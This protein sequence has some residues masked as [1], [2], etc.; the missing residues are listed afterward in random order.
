VQIKNLS[1]VNINSDFG[2]GTNYFLIFKYVKDKKG[3]KLD[4]NLVYYV[5]YSKIKSLG[6]SNQLSY[7]PITIGL[8]A[9]RS[10]QAFKLTNDS[11]HYEIFIA[12]SDWLCENMDSSG[13]WPTMHNKKIGN[14]TLFAPWPSAMSQGLGI[15]VLT[16]AYKTT[17]D[18]T[19]IVSARK[20]ILS[21]GKTIEEGGVRTNNKFGV[22]YEEYPL[23]SNSTH[24]LNGFIY[25]LYGLYDLWHLD[26]NLLAKEYFEDGVST[27]K[28]VLPMYDLG[29]W[30]SYD[31]NPNKNLRNHWGYCSPWYQKLHIAQLSSIYLITEEKIFDD[32]AKKFTQQEHSSFIN[33]IIYPAYI[34][35]TDFVYLKRSI[36]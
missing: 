6:V 12:N 25:S 9:L 5:D 11:L 35:Y 31:L 7:Y 29:N 33:Y 2:D 4:S 8:G 1:N 10:L 3:I 34:L 17:Y 13:N 36:L 15:S 16:R 19:Y 23:D 14:K 21:F 32:Y 18:S 26:S 27:L 30:T 22:F 24:V 20:A 28:T